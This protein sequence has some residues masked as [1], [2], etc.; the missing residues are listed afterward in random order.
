MNNVYISD[1]GCDGTCV[2]VYTNLTAQQVEQF[3]AD[4]RCIS[5][6]DCY[7]IPQEQLMFYCIDER[8]MLTEEQEH[9]ILTHLE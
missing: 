6:G 9:F 1:F 3:F 7:E 8:A 5:V 2:L 4:Y